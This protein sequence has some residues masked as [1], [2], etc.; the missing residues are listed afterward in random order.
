MSETP[1]N[2]YELPTEA[3]E[4]NSSTVIDLHAGNPNHLSLDRARQARH[5]AEKAFE[6]DRTLIE[7]H[8]D[9]QTIR[10][11]SQYMPAV[12]KQVLAA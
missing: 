6:E 2:S 4:M 11:V 5:L 10:Q 1:T 12:R 7:Y 3:T 9:V 8:Q